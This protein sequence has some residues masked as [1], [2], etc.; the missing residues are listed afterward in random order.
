MKKRGAAIGT[1]DGFHRGHQ[2]VVDTLIH[3]CE[4]KGLEPVV[5]TFDRHPLALIDPE[6][7]PDKLS[8]DHHRT[9]RIEKQ[10]VRPLVM[11][12]NRELQQTSAEEWLKRL[13]DE[14][15]VKLLVI[16]YDNT[17]GNDGVALSIA[18]YKRMGEMTGVEVIEARELEGISSSAIRKAVKNGEMEEAAE[19]LGRPYSLE[20]IVER[21]NG[22][23]R[24]LG[25]P[26]ANLNVGER[27][28]V[29]AS[30]VYAGRLEL[31]DHTSFPAMINIGT[32]PTIGAGDQRV[33]EIH[34]VGWSG[35]LYEK[36]LTV[37]FLKRLRE[38]KKFDSIEDLQCQLDIDREEVMKICNKKEM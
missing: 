21:G 11:E 37:E 28:A 14:F 9:R 16:G 5:V 20:G 10:G 15:G 17:F 27:I 7:E 38:E 6:R 26:T 35:D 34:A 2:S 23:G 18:D 3:Q 31:P 36:E 24:K 33:I 13:H 29:P 1:F 19:M 12:F 32:R 30:G 4:E 8:S 22:I 25:Y